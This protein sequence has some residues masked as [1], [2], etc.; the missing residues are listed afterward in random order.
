MA[1]K[2]LPDSDDDSPGLQRNL[3]K[4]LDSI[5]VDAAKRVL[6]KVA[7][8]KAWQAVIM[9]GLDVGNPIY[10]GRFRGDRG[11]E[12]VGVEVDGAPGAM[13]WEV[14]KALKGF[15]KTLQI[16]V[17]GLDAKYPDAESLDD[18][19]MEA[20]IEIAAWAHA[21]WVRIHPFANGNGRTA[22]IWANLLLMRYGLPDV[23]SLRP[24][25]GGEYGAAGAAAMKGDWVPTMRLFRSLVR[26]AVSGAPAKS[27]A[28]KA[29]PP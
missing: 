14:A 27:A 22:R 23:V 16:I 20:V 1:T 2:A 9:A 3:D 19:G 7:T 10:V 21:E 15:E 6:P 12:R 29:K 17:A 26:E 18:D 28:K 4:V 25:P 13:P 24:R 11:L 5:E 8:A